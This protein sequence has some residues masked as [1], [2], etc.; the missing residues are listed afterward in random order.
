[1][2]RYAKKG[3]LGV[4]AVLYL[5][6]G[7]IKW[8]YILNLGLV[9]GGLFLH[10][11]SIE[12]QLN[13]NSTFSDPIRYFLFTPKWVSTL[14]FGNLFLLLNLAIIYLVYGKREHINF[15]FWLFFWVS[16]T[17]FVVL[18]I[19]FLT[20]TFPIVYPIVARI[21]ELQQSPFTLFFLL[22]AFRLIAKEDAPT[23]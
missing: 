15:T 23:T 22:V 16:L 11:Y 1:M 14:V 12:A 13:Y 10:R 8:N 21:K 19:G 17:S 18:G 5:V 2:N 9:E 4:L 6:L 20:D 3:L 7:I